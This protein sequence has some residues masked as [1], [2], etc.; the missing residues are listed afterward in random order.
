MKKVT[1]T[2]HGGG[3]LS[4]KMET[5]TNISHMEP[6]PKR[7]VV[8]TLAYQLLAFKGKYEITYQNEK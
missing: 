4:Y 5:E 6:A 3:M 1:I 8:L 2:D 7:V